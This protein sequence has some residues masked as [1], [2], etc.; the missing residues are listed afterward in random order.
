[1]TDS[2][3][4]YN[5][6]YWFMLDN[7]GVFSNFYYDINCVYS[8]TDGDA[9]NTNACRL[10]DLF[11]LFAQ[12]DMPIPNFGNYSDYVD[13]FEWWSAVFAW[14]PFRGFALFWLSN[15]YFFSFAFAFGYYHY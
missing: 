2:A 3:D 1:M 8:S 6:A 13:T 11:Y 9:N 12:M 4:E 14:K 7:D 15:M 5:P 10:A